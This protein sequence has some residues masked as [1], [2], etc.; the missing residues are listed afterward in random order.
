[1]EF[2]DCISSESK[3]L[4]DDRG[5]LHSLKEIDSNSYLINDDPPLASALNENGS[6]ISFAD[7]SDERTLP[8]FTR[9]KV[10]KLTAMRARKELTYSEERLVLN[11]FKNTNLIELIQRRYLVSAL[12]SLATHDF[13][14]DW[15]SSR[16]A[17]TKLMNLKEIR[18]VEG[19]TEKVAVGDETV[20]I[21]A[22]VLATD[23]T[24]YLARSHN[25]KRSELYGLLAQVIANIFI[26]SVVPQRKF[27]DAAYRLLGSESEREVGEYLLNRGIRWKLDSASKRVSVDLEEEDDGFENDQLKEIML[28][29]LAD[30]LDQ[31]SDED[32]SRTDD[33]QKSENE[34]TLNG[35]RVHTPYEY[36]PLP[37][38]ETITPQVKPRSDSWSP[39]PPAQGRSRGSSR[40][41][42][43]P[44]LHQS[45]RDREIGRRGEEIIYLREIERVKSLG[46]SVSN[47]R[48]TA[49]TDLGAD[50]D[51]ISVDEHGKD[52]WIEVKSTTGKDG[53]FRWSRK[54]FKKALRERHHYILWR[55]YDADKINPQLK[56]FR[57]P[58]AL[59]PL[60]AIRLDIADFYAE[61]EPLDE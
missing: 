44:A 53:R 25:L 31:S 3:C 4:L 19:L 38:I 39:T 51:I 56:E 11:R 42:T 24:I 28:T 5:Y 13:Q 58:V 1:V 21:K 12:E 49:K 27:A 46:F 50:H 37:P 35:D 40:P 2:A 45:Q 52:L 41:W 34:G 59:L 7:T 60:D 14:L 36:D 55:V 15:K 32:P 47:V 57:D 33:A 18:F 16:T 54:E 48:W 30:S 6:R 43:P 9:L 20:A 8:F 17:G 23:D 26:D 22:K 29:N 61:I 10:K